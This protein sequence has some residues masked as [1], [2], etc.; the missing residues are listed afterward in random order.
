MKTQNDNNKRLND[1]GT[2]IVDCAKC[3]KPAGL[4]NI[5]KGSGL[6][7]FDPYATGVQFHKGSKGAQVHYSCLSQKRL[8]E[9]KDEQDEQHEH[10]AQS[11]VVGEDHPNNP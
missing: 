5:I 7:W 1:Q 10:Y 11:I 4:N 2:S 9:I 6:A 3:G 8:E